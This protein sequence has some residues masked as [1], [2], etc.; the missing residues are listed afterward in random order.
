[1]VIS[2]HTLDFNL[3][4]HPGDHAGLPSRRRHLHRCYGRWYVVYLR[5]A[6]EGP[7]AL[8]DSM[9][10]C[11][12][13]IKWLKC[14]NR[15]QFD[16]SRAQAT[17]LKRVKAAVRPAAAGIVALASPH[18]TLPSEAYSRLVA[19]PSGHRAVPSAMASGSHLAP[20]HRPLEG[21]P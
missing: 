17:A 11:H 5:R 14:D 2:L 4:V 7:T 1:M 6:P 3:P 13:R 9:P 20:S 8:D 18:G 21:A 15:E 19:A 12:R 10:S 16:V